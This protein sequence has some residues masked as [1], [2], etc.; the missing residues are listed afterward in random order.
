MTFEVI[1]ADPII[2]RVIRRMEAK[3]IAACVHLGSLVHAEGSYHFI[4]YDE[5][6]VAQL[7]REAISNPDMFAVVA[8]TDAKYIG[9]LIGLVTPYFFSGER[10]AQ[11]LA[12]YVRP[13]FRGGHVGSGLLHEFVKWA[14]SRDCKEICM[15][16]TTGIDTERAMKVY[17]KFGFKEAGRVMKRRIS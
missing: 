15:G 13:D 8:E 6:K 17:E 12:V 5:I 2:S 7:L 4:P 11:D 10:I 16:I 3:D 9:V 1:K 14:Q